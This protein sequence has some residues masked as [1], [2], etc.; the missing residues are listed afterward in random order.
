MKIESLTR[1]RSAQFVSFTTGCTACLPFLKAYQEVFNDGGFGI[2]SERK[3]VG[4][5]IQTPKSI[6]ELVL[7]D[8]L[9]HYRVSSFDSW[10]LVVSIAMI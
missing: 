4:D 3:D 2:E 5:R 6:E 9:L 8:H 1:V 7:N 10:T